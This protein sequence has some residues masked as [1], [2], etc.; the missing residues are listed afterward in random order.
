MQASTTSNPGAVIASGTSSQVDFA[1]GGL[2]VVWVHTTTD[3][4]EM[5]QVSTPI[6]G[7]VF[8]HV[9]RTVSELCA[10]QDPAELPVPVPVDR[11]LPQPAP[12]VVNDV[13]GPIIDEGAIGGSSP[14]EP[15]VVPVA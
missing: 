2:Q 10:E 13:P 3:P 6:Q 7:A 11:S 12:L 4:T 5:I 14:T 9:K 1:S 8:T 15:C